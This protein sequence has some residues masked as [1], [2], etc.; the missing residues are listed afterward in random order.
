MTDCKTSHKISPLLGLIHFEGT[1]LHVRFAT[2]LHLMRSYLAKQLDWLGIGA[3]A[4]CLI[5]CLV[6]PVVVSL[7]SALVANRWWLLDLVFVALATFAV[8]LA[9]QGAS[10]RVRLL[11]W[12][13]LA[14][15][16][17]G[18]LLHDLG[19]WWHYAHIPGSLFIVA[20]HILNLRTRVIGACLTQQRPA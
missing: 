2:L 15:F 4:L 12:V 16:Y 8:V 10:A 18:L 5:H 14:L 20:G 19:T 1:G 9:S 17:F 3:S 7:V 6:T 11:L 13:G